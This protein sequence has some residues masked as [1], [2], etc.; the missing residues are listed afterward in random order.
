MPSISAEKEM[1]DQL[2]SAETLARAASVSATSPVEEDER[3]IE[4]E[5]FA[6]RAWSLAETNNHAF[7]A[8]E[9]WR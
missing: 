6:D 9:I 8:S 7:V 3:Y 1:I 2:L 4:A 5:R